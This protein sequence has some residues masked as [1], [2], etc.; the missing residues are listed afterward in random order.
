VSLGGPVFDLEKLT[1]LNGRYL[2]RLSTDEFIGKLRGHLLSDAYLAE[3][4]PLVRERIDTLEGFYD[5]ASFFFVGEVSYDD[6]AL[7]AMVPKGRAASEVAKALA[8]LVE[9]AIDPM[10]EWTA[11]SI[12]SSLNTFAGEAA[13]P[14]KELYM[15]V[16]LAVT[17]RSATPPLF[18]TMAVLGKEVSRRRLRRAAET[19]RGLKE[20]R[21]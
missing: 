19:L 10:L 3:V 8:T 12:E 18:E 20:P 1:W 9:K 15:T 21:A 16:R 6:A 14:A 2:R 7:R 5:Y 11:A 4:L 13:W 17:G